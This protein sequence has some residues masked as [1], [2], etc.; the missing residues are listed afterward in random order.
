[1]SKLFQKPTYLVVNNQEVE[2]VKKLGARY[3]KLSNLY[4]APKNIEIDTF[5]KWL[6]NT[7]EQQNIV[8]NG[9][10]K[11]LEKLYTPP[12]LSNDNSDTT[13]VKTYLVVSG[14]EA[15]EKA[16]QVGA[17]FDGDKTLWYAK[18]GTKIDNIKE[19]LPDEQLRKIQPRIDKMREKSNISVGD[20]FQDLTNEM[21]KIGIVMDTSSLTSLLDGQRHRVNNTKNPTGKKKDGWLIGSIDPLSGRVTCTFGNYNFDGG[22]KHSF[23][24]DDKHGIRYNYGIYDKGS[25]GE[26]RENKEE[27]YLNYMLGLI[28]TAKNAQKEER[29]NI[30]K[31]FTAKQLAY[32]YNKAKPA[33]P[34]NPYL[35]KKGIMP[36]NA[37]EDFRG[38]LLIPLY[39]EKGKIWS[40]QKIWEDGKMI[41]RITPPAYEHI[42]FNYLAKKEGCF[43]VVG[44]DLGSLKKQNPIII[45]E[46]FATS[47]SISEALR[48]PVVMAVDS[49]NMEKVADVLR[50]EL[51]ERVL[52]IFAGDN[53]KRQETT[54]NP[55][56]GKPNRNVGKEK[57][58]HLEKKHGNFGLAVLPEFQGAD[59]M[60]GTDWN[61]FSLMYGKEAIA[62]VFVNNI[63]NWKQRKPTTTQPKPQKEQKE[64]I[65]LKMIDYYIYSVPLVHA[66][67][68]Q[69]AQ[70]AKELIRGGAN[71]RDGGDMPLMASVGY[72]K[73]V[74]TDFLIN[75]GADINAHNGLA[76]H[77]AK[78]RG[79]LETIETL[80]KN[81]DK[82]DVNAINQD[83][84]YLSDMAKKLADEVGSKYQEIVSIISNDYKIQR[85]S[86]AQCLVPTGNKIISSTGATL[87]EVMAGKDIVF[88]DGA[89]TVKKGTVGGYIAD[90]ESIKDA[91]NV[92]IGKGIVIEGA[93]KLGDGT[94]LGG[95]ETTIRDNLD[96]N[97]AETLMRNKEKREQNSVGAKHQNL[98]RVRN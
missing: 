39:D 45:A 1:M 35:I 95:V 28:S 62:K 74:T 93:V 2:T 51:G 76:F 29:D 40:T 73:A 38:N 75:K 41:G 32:E 7:R 27:E 67:S 79:D 54:I 55:S 33:S 70:K 87:H 88:N 80:L 43:S 5:K 19:W 69:N 17:L 92:W 53:D 90:I 13:K 85:E 26:E 63:N 4:Y 91:K 49:G 42:G 86:N 61:D 71:I 47:A 23:P 14:K 65:Y 98:S 8:E 84:E 57:A 82:I 11:A 97:V 77:I 31:E 18:V 89:M 6:P 22:E 64:N 66:F 36:H 48:I 16:K 59:F 44:G 46:G 21:N 58:L 60:K 52:F 30:K 10:K 50:E 9:V 24:V 96:V 15:R 83:G 25:K 68:T 81:A 94:Y 72:C 20:Q 3:D 37:K 12:P 78:E 56:T 34:N